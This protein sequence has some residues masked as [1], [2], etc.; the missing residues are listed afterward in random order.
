[1]S[2]VQQTSKDAYRF[3]DNLSTRQSNVYVW[4]DMLGSPT[5]LEISNRSH[6]PI[7]QITPR[8]NELVKM[9]FVTP[10]KKRRCGVSGR[11]AIS[12]RIARK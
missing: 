11:M 7:N 1:M 8:T 6:I 12:W 5:N 3:L 10:Y 2:N 9:G 4:I